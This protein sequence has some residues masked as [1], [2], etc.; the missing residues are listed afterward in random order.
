MKNSEMRQEFL[1]TKLDICLNE[2]ESNL[3]EFAKVGLEELTGVL[4]ELTE[5]SFYRMRLNLWITYYKASRYLDPETAEEFRELFKETEDIDHR[6]PTK[7][8]MLLKKAHS[9]LSEEKCCMKDGVSF[10]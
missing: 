5:K 7:S 9:V 2:I 10:E 6:L 8:L 3:P 1:L 4:R